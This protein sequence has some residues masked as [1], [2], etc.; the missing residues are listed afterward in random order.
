[1]G[2][3]QSERTK[4]LELGEDPHRR[5]EACKLFLI[6]APDVLKK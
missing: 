6:K 1:V 3:K 2:E 4:Q 5:T